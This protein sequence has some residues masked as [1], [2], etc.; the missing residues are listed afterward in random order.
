VTPDKDIITYC[1][2]GVRASHTFF[3]LHQLGFKQIR[4]YDGSW[5]EWSGK[6]GAK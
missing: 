5:L 6:V 2:S 4:M 3:L 1:Q